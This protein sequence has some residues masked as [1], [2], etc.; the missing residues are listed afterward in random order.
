[1]T[2]SPV[3]AVSGVPG[4]GKTT[5]CKAIQRA[6]GATIVAYDQYEQITQTPLDELMLWLDGG[7]D[8][9]EIEAP[10]LTKAIDRAAQ[11][12]P[13]ILD[14][15]LG[16][17]LP[18]CAP[19]IG[20]QVWLDCPSDLALGR[21]LKQFLDL[22]SGPERF[23]W[24]SNYLAAYPAVVRPLFLLQQERVPILADA[25]I[26]ATQSLDKSIDAVIDVARA[27]FDLNTRI[28]H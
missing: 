11:Q 6:T 27:V 16:R 4:S 9:A 21:K 3:L 25:I 20:F 1:M 26:D 5:L 24:V 14:S 23:D 2:R 19:H 28:R 13:V 17:A 22:D 18:E 8:F 7:A 10:G 15:P 12:G